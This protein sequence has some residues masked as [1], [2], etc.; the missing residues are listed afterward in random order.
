M[1]RVLSDPTT[2]LLDRHSLLRYLSV[3]VAVGSPVTSLNPENVDPQVTILLKDFH[4]V[5]EIMPQCFDC[6][7]LI[8]HVQTLTHGV[9]PDSE[10]ER[11]LA[12]V[13][14]H[15]CQ[16]II[17]LCLFFHVFSLICWSCLLV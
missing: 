14:V 10:V 9:H 1:T 6:S 5:H 3:Y 7:L 17:M 16:Y 11:G 8:L 12:M 15:T 4:K 13:G 2:G